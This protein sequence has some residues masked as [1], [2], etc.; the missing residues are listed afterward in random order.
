MGGGGGGAAG[1]ARPDSHDRPS[2][3]LSPRCGS[4]PSV[5]GE[6]HDFPASAA[7][8]PAFRGPATAAATAQSARAASPPRPLPHGAV[9]AAPERWGRYKEVE[10]TQKGRMRDGTG[11][12]VLER[13]S[14]APSRGPR[15]SRDPGAPLSSRRARPPPPPPPTTP[16]ARSCSHGRR[17]PRLLPAVVSSLRDRGAARDPRAQKERRSRRL[18]DRSGLRASPPNFP[19]AASAPLLP[20]PVTPARAPP[21]SLPRV[22]PRPRRR[23]RGVFGW[24]RAERTSLELRLR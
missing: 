4:L 5:G 8:A 7:P 13:P 6:A 20:S 12:A 22:G 19:V 2:A 3:E 1:P 21:G 17:R 23:R 24:D 16:G 9:L 15:S 10:V 18:R 11:A 14:R